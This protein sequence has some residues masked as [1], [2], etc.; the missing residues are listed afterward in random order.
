MA[1]PDGGDRVCIRYFVSRKHLFVETTAGFDDS[2]VRAPGLDFARRKS[3]DP[4]FKKAVDVVAARSKEA[5]RYFSWVMSYIMVALFLAESVEKQSCFRYRNDKLDFMSWLFCAGPDQ[6]QQLESW[7]ADADY[8]RDL[9]ATTTGLELPRARVPVRKTGVSD[10]E[11]L[12]EVIEA[13]AA[14]VELLAE[15]VG[16]RPLHFLGSMQPHR[17][18]AYRP[19]AATM[20]IVVRMRAP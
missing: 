13:C 17:I 7:L 2:G 18:D 5:P 11:W 6:A 8:L 3:R 15:G 12:D 19:V 9:V 1:G 20:N 16:L 4:K 10:S 14:A